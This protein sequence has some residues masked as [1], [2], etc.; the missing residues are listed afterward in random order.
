MWSVGCCL[1]PKS[2]PVSLEKIQCFPL[3]S[4][5][6]A[7]GLRLDFSFFYSE[8]G[9]DSF[10]LVPIIDGPIVV[11]LLPIIDSLIVGFL[12]PIIASQKK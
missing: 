10:F 2:R 12:S 9:I 3:Y 8:L 6:L 11:F 4:L 7:V 1:S 5:L